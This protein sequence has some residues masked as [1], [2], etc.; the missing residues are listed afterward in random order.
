MCFEFREDGHVLAT[1]LAISQATLHDL[2]ER[3]LLFF[4]GYSR[5]AG[6]ILSDQQS[7][8]SGG[9][10]GMLANLE[11]TKALGLRI[12]E[13]LE[14]G[15]PADFGRMMHEHWEGKR[16]R[17]EGM[18]NERIDHWYRVGRDN[19][20]IGGKVVGAGSGGFLMFYA[21]DPGALRA[22]MAAEGLKEARF[23]FDLD[24]SSVLVRD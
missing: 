15:R 16:R 5:S 9:D 20:A 13:A 8:S 4:T 24:G 2:E 3:L 1:P 18:S 17:S 22:A 23:T 19:G 12:R 6:R 11:N 14:E 7:R 21:E 10:A